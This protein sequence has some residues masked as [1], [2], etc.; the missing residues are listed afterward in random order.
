MFF[1]KEEDNFNKNLLLSAGVHVILFLF[2]FLFGKILQHTFKGSDNVEI[3]RASVRVDV[4]G[5]PKFTIKE[6]RELERKQ[7]MATQPEVVQGGK[8]ETKKEEADVINKNDLVIEEKTK[9]KKKNSFM[10]IIN[11]YSSKKLATKEQVKGESTG[12]N[13]SH[14]SSLIIEGNRLSKGSSLVGDYSDEANSEFSAYVQTLPAL[15]RQF[16]K[17]PSYLKDQ[18]LRCK[19]LLFL[20]PNGHVLKTELTET[21]GTAEFDARAE[22]A[23]RDAAP[24]PSPNSEVGARLVN[25]GIILRFPL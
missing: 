15:V 12:T 11:D 10:N 23:I 13:T 3:I 22:K 4:V 24:F 21:S 9:E 19:I 5:M 7:D 20:S 6:L 18:D 17:L 25:S 2:A 14:L 16:W 1:L 8:I